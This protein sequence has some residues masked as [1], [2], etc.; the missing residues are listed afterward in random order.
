MIKKI[1]FFA[2]FISLNVNLFSQI[3]PRKYDENYMYTVFQDEFNGSDINRQDWRA[4]L[5][6]RGIGQLIDS[7][8]TYDVSNGKL[9]L[10]MAHVP[11]YNDSAN[12]VGQE[13]LTNNSFLYGSFECKATFANEIGSWP[14]FWS[15][16]NSSCQNGSDVPEIDFA[17]YFCKT[18]NS[19]NKLG[20]YIHHW[21]CGGD[22]ESTYYKYDY[23]FS[24][25]T[26]IFKSIWTPE[27]IDFFVNNVKKVT[28]YNNGQDWYPYQ[29]VGVILS[30]QITQPFNYIGQEINPI[31]PQTSYFDYVNIKK[32]F[33]APEI[34]IS[35]DLICTSG[36]ATLDVDTEATNITWSL[37]PSYLFSGST[38]G[39][40]KTASFNVNLYA[41]GEGTITYSFEMPSG[42][43]FDVEKDFWVGA[44]DPDQID[45]ET[46]MQPGGHNL[47]EGDNTIVV[48]SSPSIMDCDN[49]I[50]DM[51]FNYSNV[52]PTG[53]MITVYNVNDNNGSGTTDISI[54]AH[55]TCGV[56]SD[57]SDFPITF[58]ILSGWYMSFSPNPTTGETTLTINS[59]S[60]EKV[61]DANAVWEY[62]VYNAGQRLKAKQ[63][64]L[65]GSS[66]TI[67]TQGWQEGVYVVRVKFSTDGKTEEILTGKLVVKE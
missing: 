16:F 57:F 12:Y 6:Y 3:N 52:A 27:K 21:I 24:A 14:A 65:R 33:L 32:F 35:S 34:T 5:I 50:Y 54:K 40:G 19:N 10:T 47:N 44:P 39:P 60:K 26:N 53:E 56:W 67:Q 55:N 51:D 4:G 1:L 58:T 42:E 59:T 63:T 66:T 15:F 22:K 30:Q 62:E 18:P 13:F 49:Y 38:S 61:L 37:S 31:C 11:N 64:K 36:T 48:T 20:H 8:L 17:E 2:I 29:A 43:T 28:F 25:S 9:E 45:F 41:N 46:F 7:S 23:N